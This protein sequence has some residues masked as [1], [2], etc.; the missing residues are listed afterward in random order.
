MYEFHTISTIKTIGS[1]SLLCATAY[2]ETTLSLSGTEVYNSMFP[3]HE[4]AIIAN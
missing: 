4:L 3:T 1:E 2:I